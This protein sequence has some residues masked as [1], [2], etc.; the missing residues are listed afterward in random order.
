MKGATCWKSRYLA[1][2]AESSKPQPK[3]SKLKCR[4]INGSA[5]AHLV[6][7]AVLAAGLDG[8]DRGVEPPA[9]VSGDSYRADGARSLPRSLNAALDALEVDEA[10]V[11]LL[12]RELV[13]AFVTLKRYEADRFDAYVTDWEVSEYAA[14]L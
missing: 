3:A 6:A 2:I 13:D 7:A 12:G 4:K 8:I 9:E 10:L 5:N 1:V 14:H 11:E